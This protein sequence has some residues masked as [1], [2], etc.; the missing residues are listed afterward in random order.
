MEV[1]F[2]STSGSRRSPRRPGSGVGGVERVLDE[3]ED[4]L[5]VAVGERPTDQHLVVGDVK[6]DRVTDEGDSRPV[7]S[8]T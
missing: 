3:D 5:G 8:F 1:P 4:A 7:G 6:A 2:L